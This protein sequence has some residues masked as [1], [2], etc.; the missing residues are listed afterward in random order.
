MCE[1]P[2]AENLNFTG[3]TPV[4][5]LPSSQTHRLCFF[6]GAP[7]E[8]KHVIVPNFVAYSLRNEPNPYHH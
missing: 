3:M 4:E 2:Q 7:L 5:S 1:S 8:H 6:P